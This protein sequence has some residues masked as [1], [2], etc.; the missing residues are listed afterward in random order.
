VHRPAAAL[1]TFPRPTFP[2][3]N[4]TENLHDTPRFRASGCEK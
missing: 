4:E 1:T 2:I 3:T